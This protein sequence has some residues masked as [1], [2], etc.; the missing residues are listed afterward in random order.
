MKLL[1]HIV[2]LLKSEAKHGIQQLNVFLG[3]ILHIKNFIAFSFMNL[4][5]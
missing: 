1:N 5:H 2:D 3:K 4:L